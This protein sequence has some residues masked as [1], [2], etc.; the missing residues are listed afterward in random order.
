MQERGAGVGSVTLAMSRLTLQAFRVL[1]CGRQVCPMVVTPNRKLNRIVGGARV[2][3]TVFRCRAL[4]FSLALSA[5]GAIRDERFGPVF[6]TS[7]VT[8]TH[9]S[10]GNRLPSIRPLRVRL[11]DSPRRVLCLLFRAITGT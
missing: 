9:T 3:V 4:M 7:A 8:I 11:W 2:V 10:L 5:P 1:L 6:S